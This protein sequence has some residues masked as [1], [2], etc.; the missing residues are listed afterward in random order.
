MTE[1]TQNLADGGTREPG[2]GFGSDVRDWESEP[3]R[4]TRAEAA[5][6]HLASFAKGDQVIVTGRSYALEGTVTIPQQ[7]ARDMRR[8]WLIVTGT[9]TFEDGQ[10][11]WEQRPVECVITVDKMLA[12]RCLT[13]ATDADAAAGSW[14]YFDAATWAMQNPEG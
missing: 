12:G 13:L 8:A 10:G 6:A 5:Y 1:I 11:G 3:V 2:D 14:Q 7:D 4:L 9:G